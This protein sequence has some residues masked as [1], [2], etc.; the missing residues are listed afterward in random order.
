MRQN[1]PGQTFWRDARMWPSVSCGVDHGAGAGHAP[2]REEG[3]GSCGSAGSPFRSESE[4][5]LRIPSLP[6]A[7]RVTRQW[8]HLG[9][10][11]K[12]CEVQCSRS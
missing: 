6:L 3:R 2:L 4:E 10:F 1:I 9:S 5:S 7:Q 12:S 8:R 11:V